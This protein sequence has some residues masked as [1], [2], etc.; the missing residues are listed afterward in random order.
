MAAPSDEAHGVPR[1]PSES[2]P[3]VIL[4][5]STRAM[6]HVAVVFAVWLLAAGH[7]RPGGGFVGGLTLSAALVLIYAGGGSPALRRA[8]PARPLTFLGLGMLLTQATAVV[9]LWFGRG[10]LESA[11]LTFH[12]PV[13]GAVKVITTLF[14]D[15]G[16]MLIVLGLVAKALD[17]LGAADPTGEQDATMPSGGTGAEGERR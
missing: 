17:T 12:L 6:F 5:V 11:A 9:P 16:V 3:S 4:A 15:I 13:F 1:E 10:L 8:L 14:F 2:P 7:N